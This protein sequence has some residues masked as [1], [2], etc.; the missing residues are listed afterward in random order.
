MLP[1]FGDSDRRRKINLG[2]TSSA[3]SQAAILD[4]AKARRTERE[5]NR[6]RQDNAIRLQAWWRGVREVRA[7]RR[8]MKYEFERDVTG[9][10]GMRCLVLMGGDEDALA[11]WSKT[12][13]DSGEGEFVCALKY[14]PESDLLLQTLSFISPLAPTN[15][16]G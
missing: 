9:L 12:V 16:A 14:V 15:E 11:L 8:Q 2:G 7:V 10:K 6:R 4:Q 13:V 5:D 3:T 1:L